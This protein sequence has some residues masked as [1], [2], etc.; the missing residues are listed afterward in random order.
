MISTDLTQGSVWKKLVNYAIPLVLSSALQATYGIVDMIVSGHYIG[1]SALSAITNSNQIMTMLTNIFIGL[2]TGGNI[3]IGQLFGAKKR[4]DCKEAT[5][6][7]FTGSI[8]SGAVLS[9]VFYFLS[10]T[11]LTVMDAPTLDEAT[12]YLQTCTIGIL[13]IVGYNACSAA[14][15]AIGNS[16]VPLI[17]VAATAVSNIVLDILFV[18]PMG[19]G[20]FGAA[21]ATIIAQAISFIVS[22]YFVLRDK[23]LFGLSISNLYIRSDKL[24][25]I[26]RFGV[27][28]AVQMSVGSISWLSVTY[29]INQYGQFVSAASGV[30]A[31]IKEFCQLFISAMMNA[32]ASMIAQCI[33]ARELERARK[34]MYT[35]MA[36]TVSMSL[37]L[38]C[39]V[40][41]IAPQL[42]SLF[43]DEAETAVYAVKNLR[44]EILGQ[45]FYAS[46]LV[47]HSLAL[48]SGHTWFAFCSSFVNCILVRIVLAVI[49]RHYFGLNGI[50]WACMIAPFSSVPIGLWYERSNRWQRPIVRK[51]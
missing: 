20:V 39:I 41:A 40:H 9:L 23:E 16:K 3:L 38:I 18:G 27:P 44:I 19:L 29:L 15:R 32:A 8:L 43:T 5:V 17:C 51:G 10:R 36:I 37:V 6:T 42:V 46:F 2:T 49:F 13:F 50:Y 24:R 30:A 26:L 47:Y 12:V 35:A 45:V 22:L 7:L 48:G 31:K 11:M 4:E 34:V 33:G 21:L 25:T 14:L 1:S 28:V